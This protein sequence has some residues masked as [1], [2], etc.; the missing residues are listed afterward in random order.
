MPSLNRPANLA[1]FFQACYA[2]AVS[3]PGAVLIDRNDYAANQAAYEALEMPIGWQ[4]WQTE[5]VTQGDKV[6]EVWARVVN[7]AWLGLIGDDNIP[8]TGRWDQIMVSQLSESGIVSCNDGWQAPQRIANCWI[9]SGPVVR[10]VGYIFAPGLHHMFVDD[11]WE[12]L[13]SQTGAWQCRM[14]VMVRHTHVM[15]GD[16][17]PD[18]THRAAYGE[19]FTKS[20]PGPDETAGLWAGDHRIYKHWRANPCHEAI[21]AIMELGRL[22]P[23]V[24]WLTR[25]K[26]RSI[27]IATPVARRPTWQYQT[28]ALRTHAHLQK[29]GIRSIMEQM[30]GNPD[31]PRARNELVAA[32]LASDYDDMLMIDDDIGWDPGDVVRLLA[33]PHP[34]IAGVGAKR[35]AGVKDHD[36]D[37][38]CCRWLGK[39][40][41]QD[42]MGN[43]RVLAVGTGFMRIQRQVFDKLRAAHPEW[44]L[45][46][47]PNMPQNL[48]DKYYRFFRFPEDDPDEPGEDYRFCQDWIALGGE[49]WIDPSI[50]LVHVGEA[51]YS[52]DIMALFRPHPE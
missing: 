17:E 43:L 16:A 30:I 47:S 52:G 9:M 20:H 31:L 42:R 35:R 38:W 33:S 39:D 40:V 23:S 11:I 28:A 15:K 49:I 51:E 3:T 12:T 7:C 32:F 1:R 27:Y 36:H 34:V 24:A 29:L 10:A 6:R 44:K 21:R 26:T 19:G 45:N 22:V 25:A 5:G 13:G 48:K 37:K 14:D 2:T 41:E 18:D 4:I 46:G 8:E 50:K